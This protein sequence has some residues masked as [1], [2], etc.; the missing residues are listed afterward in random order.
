MQ[1][2]NRERNIVDHASWTK[3]E[4]KDNKYDMSSLTSLRQ[5]VSSE[6]SNTIT[7][8]VRKTNCEIYSHG[9]K[10]KKI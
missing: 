1:S 3:K 4:K 9:K 2:R 6:R 7:R 5:S 8:A 10:K